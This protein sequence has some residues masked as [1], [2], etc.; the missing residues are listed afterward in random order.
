MLQLQYFTKLQKKHIDQILTNYNIKYTTMKNEIE[1]KINLMIKSFNQDISEFLNNMAEIADQRQQL[2]HLERNQNELETVREQLKDKIHEQTKLKREIDLLKMENTRL[3]N[4]NNNNSN[5]NTNSQRLFS[6]TSRGTHQSSNNI[7]LNQTQKKLKVTKS[8]FYRTERKE[9]TKEIRFKSPSNFGMRHKKKITDLV[10]DDKHKNN[11]TI[12][13]KESNLA[14]MK[15]NIL[16]NSANTELRTEPNVNKTIKSTKN[17]FNK[18][19]EDMIVV[20]KK[21][22]NNKNINLTKRI[23]NTKIKLVKKNYNNRLFNSTNQNFKTA[24]KIVSKNIINKANAKT[25]EIKK[26][27]DKEEDEN[28]K[29]DNITTNKEKTSNSNSEDYSSESES[30]SNSKSRS[31]SISKSR[32]KSISKSKSYTTENEED[33]N[34]DEEID[35][36]IELEDEIVSLMEQIKV[37]KEDNEK[38]KDKDKDKDKDK[39]NGK[40]T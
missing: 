14:N 1:N 28:E 26:D 23:N 4:F 12:I 27:K 17:I 24:K 5:S 18:N 29:E 33:K 13:K 10:L 20:N 34:I 3:K 7:L 21:N 31:K 38:N 32:N 36:M 15:K 8:N 25:F 37:F 6:P 16:F 11:K 2:K 40:L 22:Y 9:R 19:K 39:G 30:R 35:E